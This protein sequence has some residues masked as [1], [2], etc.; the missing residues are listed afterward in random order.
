[1]QQRQAKAAKQAR[2]LLPAGAPGCALALSDAK[3]HVD[4]VGKG[5]PV[6]GL[7]DERQA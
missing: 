6:S 7:K 1:M 5:E 4:R 3:R 2:H